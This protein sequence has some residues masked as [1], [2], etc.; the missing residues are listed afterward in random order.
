MVKKYLTGTTLV[1]SLN[2][3]LA[4]ELHSISDAL[5]L[6]DPFIQN[7]W[8]VELKNTLSG[9]HW[10]GRGSFVSKAIK[11][12]SFHKTSEQG[13]NQGGM[14]RRKLINHWD[15]IKKSKLLNIFP[16]NGHFFLLESFDLL[17]RCNLLVKVYLMDFSKR[18]RYMKIQSAVIP[19]CQLNMKCV[20][21]MFKKNRYCLNQVMRSISEEPFKIE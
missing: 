2:I 10:G 3:K 1:G 11:L 8:P 7:L 4:P 20:K 12:S 16:I 21:R 15:T 14:P 17:D 9:M 18:I 13:M 19:M 5:A 6:L